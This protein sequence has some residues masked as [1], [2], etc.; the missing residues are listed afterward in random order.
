VTKDSFLE[1]QT[2]DISLFSLLDQVNQCFIKCNDL[3]QEKFKVNFSCHNLDSFLETF[4]SKIEPFSRRVSF[5]DS[6]SIG[7][8]L[9]SLGCEIQGFIELNQIVL[10][11]LGLISVDSHKDNIVITNEAMTKQINHAQQH[12]EILNR[13]SSR[14]N[15]FG[16]EDSPNY[17]NKVGRIIQHIYDYDK[18]TESIDSIYKAVY[19][20]CKDANAPPFNLTPKDFVETMGQF[21]NTLYIIRITIT[22]EKDD[23][24]SENNKINQQLQTEKQ[25]YDHAFLVMSRQ[26]ERRIALLKRFYHHFEVHK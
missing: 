26:C 22:K 25:K 3:I 16:S 20:I 23:F 7:N 15:Y 14:I 4:F 8:I 1:S 21:M 17:F 18:T 10:K 11:F 24:K 12:I 13:L 9:S 6:L 2:K 19:F 5:S